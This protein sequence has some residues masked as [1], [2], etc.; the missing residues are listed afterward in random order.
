VLSDD[1]EE[2]EEVKENNYGT[3]NTLI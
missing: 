1:D 3:Q 2:Q